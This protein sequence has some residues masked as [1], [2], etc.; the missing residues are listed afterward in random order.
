MADDSIPGKLDALTSRVEKIEVA[1]AENT[2]ITRDIRDAVV[3]GRVMARVIKWTGAVAAA[4]SAIWVAIWQ[5]T[6]HG[7]AP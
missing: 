6:H 1:V 5:M 4:C 2:E 3:A 7:K